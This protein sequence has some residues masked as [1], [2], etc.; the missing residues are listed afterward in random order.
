VGDAL[1]VGREPQGG[2]VER[3]KLRAVVLKAGRS[4]QARLQV[5]EAGN[6]APKKC[7]P[8]Q[9]EGFRVYP[10]NE[11]RSAFVRS[12]RPPAATTPCTC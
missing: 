6:Y 5:T 3:T 4:A 12:P 7:R 1:L 8:A 10:P 9:A 11:K 2:R